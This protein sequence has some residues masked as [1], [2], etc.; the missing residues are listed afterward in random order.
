MQTTRIL[1]YPQGTED[2]IEF[3]EM[4]G[5][6][7]V[8]AVGDRVQTLNRDGMAYERGLMFEVVSRTFYG[9]YYGLSSYVV[10]VS[11]EVKV[12]AS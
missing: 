10:E 6:C 7:P 3:A 9:T 12:A 8:P 11:L 5:A 1:L 2:E 4:E